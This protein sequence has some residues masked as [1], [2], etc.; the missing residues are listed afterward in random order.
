VIVTVKVAAVVEEHASVADPDPVTLGGV[1]EPQVRPEGTVSVRDTD[2]LKPLTAVT[3]IV[4]VADWPTSMA[5][6]E[7]AVILKS[8]TLMTTVELLVEAPL[9]PVT[10]I[11]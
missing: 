6:G 10:V 11:A 9:V 1:M 2:P 5:A 3:V 4:D 7:V 8:T